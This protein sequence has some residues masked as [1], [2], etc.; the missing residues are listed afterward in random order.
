MLVFYPAVCNAKMQQ[1]KLISRV[2]L[3]KST[4]QAGTFVTPLYTWNTSSEEYSLAL[5]ETQR[6]NLIHV[7]GTVW[8]AS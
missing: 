2:T 1:G 4:K 7:I 3:F 6:I 5:K 8:K